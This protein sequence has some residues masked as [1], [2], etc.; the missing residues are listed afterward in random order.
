[1][2]LALPIALIIVISMVGFGMAMVMLETIGE[3]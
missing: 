1:M 2:A 3:E